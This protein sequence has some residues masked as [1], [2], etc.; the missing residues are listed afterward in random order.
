[1]SPNPDAGRVIAARLMAVLWRNRRAVRDALVIAGV[2]RAIWYYAIQRQFAWEFVGTD[3]LAYW[4]VDLAHPFAHSVEGI[5]SS[6]VYPPPLAQL[7]TPLSILPFPLF[8]AAWTVM[9]LGVLVWLVRPWPWAAL[10]LLL[11]ISW[12][13]FVGQVHLFIAAAIVLGFAHPSLW[14]LPVLTK[15]TPSVGLAWFA[16]RRE[17]RALATA[18]AAIVTVVAVSVALSPGAWSDWIAFIIASRGQG[19]LLWVRVLV[20]VALVGFGGLTDRRW[21]V[22]VG[23][24]ISLPV[25][26]VESWVILLAIIRLRP[27]SWTSPAPTAQPSSVPDAGGGATAIPATEERQ[28]AAD[29]VRARDPGPA[30]RQ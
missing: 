26:W 25:V 22:P 27:E 29:R 13:I 2:A 12:E 15:L 4:R 28:V 18:V 17:W 30:G 10:I 16:V 9:L 6:Y 24:F 21:L 19:E 5:P 8:H 23:V 3:A 20:G 11:P 14:A 1:M 7:L